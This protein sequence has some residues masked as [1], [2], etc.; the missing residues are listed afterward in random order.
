MPL[1]EYKKYLAILGYKGYMFKKI[2]GTL[3]GEFSLEVGLAPGRGDYV[4]IVFSSLKSA[5]M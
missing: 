2:K 1:S 5:Q 3:C 4:K